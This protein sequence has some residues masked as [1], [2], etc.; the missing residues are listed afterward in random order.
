MCFL[1]H[2]VA[3]RKYAETGMQE[4]QHIIIKNKRP[5]AQAGTSTNKTMPIALCFF[6]ISPFVLV[7]LLP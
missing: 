7:T 4:Q 3:E 2:T 5:H 6:L 1:G